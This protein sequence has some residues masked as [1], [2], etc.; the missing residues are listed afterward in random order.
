[1]FHRFAFGETMGY[2]DVATYD[3]GI[4][5]MDANFL[6]FV[7]EDMNGFYQLMAGFLESVMNG[8]F[9][10]TV[11]VRLKLDETE[12]FGVEKGTICYASRVTR[13]QLCYQ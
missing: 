1:M 6:H 10:I 4:F 8:F 5:E 9:G 2:N 13:Y 12:L 7:C 3:G 11:C